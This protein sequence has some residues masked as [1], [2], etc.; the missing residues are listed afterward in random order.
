MPLFSRPDGE[1][2]RDLS[3]VRRIM[4]YLM[5]GRNESAVYHKSSYDL[6]RALPWLERYNATHETK[7]T[8]FHLFLFACARGLHERPGLNRFVAGGRIYARNAVVISFAAKKS[9]DDEAPIVTVKLDFP[10]DETF[11]DCVKRILERVSSG[12][13]GKKTRVDGELSLA[14]AVPGFVLRAAL[15]LLR[16]LDGLNLM[17]ASMIASDPLY[18]SLFVANLGSVGIGDTFHHLYEYGTV[19]L[20]GAMG[21]ADKKVFVDEGGVPAVREGVEVC[22]TFDERVNDG[23]YCAGALAVVQRVLE[24]PETH[25]GD[26]AT[27]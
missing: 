11:S 25:L 21:K 26:P 16:W 8:L 23:F 24:D 22:W 4:P 18:A 20:F 7:A 15:G 14:L 5:R 6:G 10:K 12:R 9:F 13:S 17:P 3:P 1:P 27:V 19:T 2:I